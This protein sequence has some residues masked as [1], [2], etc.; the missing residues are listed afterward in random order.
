METSVTSIMLLPPAADGL[1]DLGLK[2]ITYLKMVFHMGSRCTALA[3]SITHNT[4]LTSFF[5]GAWC[6]ICDQY[7]VVR[8]TRDFAQDLR[9]SPPHEQPGSL[10]ILKPLTQ[11]LD[12]PLGFS[13]QQPRLGEG[14]NRDG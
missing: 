11:K 8:R 9:K 13:W 2:D 5:Q 14:V 4:G 10:R 3:R 7:A 6:R 12:K 1:L